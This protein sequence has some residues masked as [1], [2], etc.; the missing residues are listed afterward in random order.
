GIWRANNFKNV[1]AT[2]AGVTKQTNSSLS[3]HTTP[4]DVFSKSQVT[5]YKIKVTGSRFS[6][7]D[8]HT[9][10]KE[11]WVVARRYNGF[12]TLHKQLKSQVS[13]LGSR[14][15]LPTLPPKRTLTKGFNEEKFVMERGR[16][17]NEYLQHLLREGNALGGSFE[18]ATFLSFIEPIEHAVGS[19]LNKTEDIFGRRECNRTLIQVDGV[20]MSSNSN[21]NSISISNSSSSREEVKKGALG[22]EIKEVDNQTKTNEDRIVGDNERNSSDDISS[23]T[24]TIIDKNIS[25][26]KSSNNP[27]PHPYPHH[28]NNSHKYK[29]KHSF[30]HNTALMASVQGRIKTVSYKDVQQ[31]VFELA[32]NLFDLDKANFMRSRIIAVVKSMAFF[33]T[34]KTFYKTLISLH[35]KHVTGEKVATCFKYLRE[36]IWPNGEWMEPAEELTEQ[37][38]KE[39]YLQVKKNLDK[40]IPELIVN[41]VG[42][43]MAHEGAGILLELAQNEII[44]K[45]LSFI[46]LDCVIL[47]LYPELSIDLDV[48]NSLEREKV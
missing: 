14:L 48:L 12:V 33:L 5:M 8:P 13:S 28:N 47:E 45:S 18:L 15:L 25:N 26:K 36:T 43:K 3:H 39:N 38:K 17:L 23:P 31:N 29:R 40:I 35:K 16:D 22:V 6:S 24:I 11:E 37:E 32:K 1:K 21:S 9:I 34:E 41:V 7:D 30:A 46:L 44:M 2:I 10:V 4:L 27:H 19:K 42:E 20:K